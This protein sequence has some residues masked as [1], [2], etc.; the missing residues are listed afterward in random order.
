M[1]VARLVLAGARVVSR[2]QGMA[3]LRLESPVA[4]GGC[5]AQAACGGGRERVIEV[6]LSPQ[7]CAGDRVSLQMPE[8]DLNRGAL[9]AYL[10]PAI[11]TLFGALLLAGGGDALAV[12]GAASGLALGL[13][14]LRLSARHSPGQVIRVGR[15]DSSH[16]EVP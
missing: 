13:V 2:D 1:I 3:R 16:G 7:L 12:L 9:L 15:F 5:R 8:A 6:A 4:C 14:C 10:L 11:T